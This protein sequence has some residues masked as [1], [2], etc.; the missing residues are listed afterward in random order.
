MSSTSVEA[1]ARPP[2]PLCLP[3]SLLTL[4]LEHLPLAHKFTQ[5][6]HLCHSFPHLDSTH[7]T[8]DAIDLQP[9]IMAVLAASPPLLHLLGNI[10]CVM[11]HD[12]HRA[13]VQRQSQPPPPPPQSTP[14]SSRV[15]HQPSKQAWFPRAQRVSM[16]GMVE[17]SPFA[18]LR[19]MLVPQPPPLS[20]ATISSL[21]LPPL[22]S[23]R[24]PLIHTLRL[25]VIE[26]LGEPMEH[27]AA[28]LQ[29]LTLLPLLRTLVI[30]ELEGGMDYA[31]FRFLC[32]LPLT[33]LD[34]HGVH[35]TPATVTSSSSSGGVETGDEAAIE[36]LAV[37]DT[38]RVLRLPTFHPAVWSTEVMF[39]TVL[40]A[41]TGRDSDMAAAGLRYISLETPQPALV[42]S[43]LAAVR[44]LQSIDVRLQPRLGVLADSGAVDLPVAP[45]LTSSTCPSTARWPSPPPPPPPP[46]PSL[47]HLRHLRIRNNLP[48]RGDL[49]RV[50]ASQH[51]VTPS[52][53]YTQLLTAYSQQLRVLSISRLLPFDTRVGLLEAIAQ[54]SQLRVFELNGSIGTR[55]E[56]CDP[57]SLQLQVQLPTLP[58]L[59][60]LRLRVPIHPLDALMLVNASS[61]TLEDYRQTGP[62]PL[63]LDIVRAIGSQC[64]QLRR[65]ECP[66]EADDA[67]TPV[68]SAAHI[69][70]AWLPL[71]SSSSVPLF[72][73][74]VSLTVHAERRVF[75][76][77]ASP[78]PPVVQHQPV[79]LPAIPAVVVLPF[80]STSLS[81]PHVHHSATSPSMLTSYSPDPSFAF[82]P[83]SLPGVHMQLERALA[84]QAA[85]TPTDPPQLSDRTVCELA[86]I[87]AH[88]PVRYLDA[89]GVPLL[90]AHR[91]AP[92]TQLRALRCQQ[93]HVQL[94][95]PSHVYV[96]DDSVMPPQLHRYFVVQ[97]VIAP[98]PATRDQMDAMLLTSELIDDERPV[99]DWQLDDEA[100]GTLWAPSCQQF[101]RERQFE[102]GRDGREAFMVAVRE[103]AQERQQL[104]RGEER[105]TGKR[106]RVTENAEYHAHKRTVVDIG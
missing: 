12:A 70:S 95:E 44:T 62:F 77:P 40:E 2:L 100:R 28:S 72:P 55:V 39:D 43:R 82:L 76:P 4:V 56:E 58:H 10:S 75:K 59:H 99:G 1:A 45:F 26:Q 24:L 73:R 30:D 27:T 57:P 42:F 14:Q 7:F 104:E 16:T 71:S 38:W 17:Q 6:T 61:G 19:S 22:P 3:A 85:S 87:L 89:A 36:R 25:S 84:S 92:L 79:P 67:T 98:Q 46:L 29:P 23:V 88:S 91:F 74:L 20:T 13:V 53:P 64:R 49:P 103:M 78:T 8:Y 93:S 102:A 83:T 60:T 101:V 52:M 18:L 11:L 90:S 96:P 48:A 33:H 86:A 47:P 35:V 9:H 50:V 34:L 15:Q 66:I 80:L 69:L 37:T 63:P 51:P 81:L 68:V 32:S 41:Y 5:C 106:R 54:C 105:L 21:S 65:L 97:P 94:S 31:A